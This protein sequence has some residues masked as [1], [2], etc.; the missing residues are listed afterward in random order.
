MCSHYLPT[1][2]RQNQCLAAKSSNSAGTAR[3]AAHECTYAS[4]SV[5]L[6][7]QKIVPK[8]NKVETD[9]GLSWCGI[10]NHCTLD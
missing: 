4:S 3:L 2:D 10:T 1:T 8:K 7:G 5:G 9:K 6:N